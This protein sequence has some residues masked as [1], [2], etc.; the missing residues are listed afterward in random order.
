MCFGPIPFGF[1]VFR[2]FNKT[3]LVKIKII[4]SAN[5]RE[6]VPSITYMCFRNQITR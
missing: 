4:T 2:C 3:C 1:Y 6:A 5:V